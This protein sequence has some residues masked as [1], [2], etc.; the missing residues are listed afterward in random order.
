SRLSFF[1]WSSIPDETLLALAE[2]GKLSEPVVLERE[3]RRMLGD[4]RASTFIN[5][6]TN[7][8]LITRNARSHD[9]DPD[10]FPDIDENL[11]EAIARETE[12]F[13][14]SQ[15]REDH[16]ALDLLRANYTFLNERLARHYGIPNVYGSHFRRVTLT[17]EHRFGLLGKASVHMVTAY[18]N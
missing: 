15:V 16:A 3:V 1:L 14:E 11:Q 5:N 4:R 18:A 2:Q 9:L 17:D 7:Q 6:F 10:L 8:W 12:M 13:L